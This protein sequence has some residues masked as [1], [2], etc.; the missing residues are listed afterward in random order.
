MPTTMETVVEPPV[1]VY[2]RLLRDVHSL[3]RQG[4]GDTAEAESLADEMDGP[5]YSMS[6]QEQKRM[7]G[8]SQDLYA[9]AE[10]GAKQIDMSEEEA[11]KWREEAKATWLRKST[12]DIDAALSFLR[13]PFPNSVP[14]YTIP[15]LQAICWRDLGDLETALIFMKES[16][17]LDPHQAI[18]VLHLL[19][20]LARKDEAE[21]CARK[22]LSDST[23]TPEEVYV[24]AA[25]LLRSIRN[26]T[27]AQSESLVHQLVATLERAVAIYESSEMYQR[28]FPDFFVHVAPLLG[29]YYEMQGRPDKEKEIY[30][31]AF[32]RH[33]DSGDLYM[34]RGMAQIHDDQAGAARDFAKAVELGSFSATPYLYLAHLALQH[35]AFGRAQILARAGLSRA[36]P[37][38][39]KAKLLEILALAI[40]QNGG[41]AANV[42]E[43]LEQARVLDPS[44]EE[45][46]FNL[47]LTR[48]PGKRE[49][50]PPSLELAE[51][52]GLQLRSE[53]SE[54]A[55]E[56]SEQRFLRSPEFV[57]AA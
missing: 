11:A 3:I 31:K 24:A 34:Y 28:Q 53:I 35:Y 40:A 17:R 14:Q 27:T 51:M 5:W 30:D 1:R 4:K 49:W 15:F 32:A 9:I 55:L 38:K 50:R 48:D 45:I 8:L 22:M 52:N 25:E 26:E 29:R 44:N 43:L 16:E 37:P 21:S 41:S 57:S 47:Q 19:T 33:P 39:G 56:A 7:R 54:Q 18:G 12:G 23:S 20:E 2:A 6:D 13:Q 42:Q 36:A 46:L 10:G